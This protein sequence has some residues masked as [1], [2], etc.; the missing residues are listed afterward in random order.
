[1]KRLVVES[2]KEAISLD[3]IIQK[4]DLLEMSYQISRG[5]KTRNMHPN[6]FESILHDQ[7]PFYEAGENPIENFKADIKGYRDLS[8]EE[9]LDYFIKLKRK[10]RESSLFETWK[11][12]INEIKS[13]G[14]ELMSLLLEF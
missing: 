13:S 6:L 14:S 7:S 11:E 3:D 8:R 5:L 2:L 9:F 10:I 1:M 12:A 4:V